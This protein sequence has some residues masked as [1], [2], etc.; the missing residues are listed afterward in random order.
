MTITK[1]LLKY[2]FRIDD[3]IVVF[4]GTKTQKGSMIVPVQTTQLWQRESLSKKLSSLLR[5]KYNP[6]EKLIRIA[7]QTILMNDVFGFEDDDYGK[8]LFNL[9]TWHNSREW[10][11]NELTLKDIEKADAIE[12]MTIL[13][14]LRYE[15]TSDLLHLRL[16]KVVPFMCILIHPM[17]VKIPVVSI[18]YFLNIHTHYAFNSIRKAKHPES[19]NLIDYLYEVLYL[20][21]KTAIAIHEFLKRVDYADKNKNE[22]LMINAEINAIMNADQIFSYLKATIEKIIV[23]VGLIYGIKNLDSKKTHKA[24]LSTLK[25]KLPKKIFDLYY[26]QFMFELFSSENLDELNNYRSGLLHKRGI[27][28]LQPHNYVD[29]KPE[30]LPLKKI[31]M[32]IHDQHSKNT[33]ALLGALAL[34]T[35]K[36]VELDMPDIK[37]EEIPI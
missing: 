28:D 6:T 27:S 13:T 35:D 1:Y 19:D 22:A 17:I 37:F 29:K 32:V 30:T 9:M 18:Q 2:I 15:E 12:S 31:F 33:A 14:R 7:A 36:L 26:F 16:F 23:V 11:L 20:Q 10:N 3:E 5:L 34:L 24:K 25:E 21:Q 8:K 4:M